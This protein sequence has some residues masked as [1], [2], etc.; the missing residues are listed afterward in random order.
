[1]KSKTDET[2][3]AV[4]TTTLALCVFWIVISFSCVRIQERPDSPL[5]NSTPAAVSQE[6]VPLVSFADSGQDLGKG[7]GNCV[8]LGDVDGDGDIDALYSTGD[9]PSSLRLNDGKGIFTLSEQGFLKSSHAAFGDLNGDSYSDIFFTE[10]TSNQVWL[11]DGKGKF[12]NTDQSLVSPE[13]SSVS[14]GDIDGDGDLD[15]FVTNWGNK[16]DQV[17]VNNGKGKFT[18][19][20]QRLG[21]FSG[22]SIALGDVDKDGD[23]DA[24]VSNNGENSDNSTVLWLNDGKGIFTDSAQRLGLTNAYGVALGDLDGDGDLDAFIANS[25][26]GGANPADTV[27]MNDGRGIFTDSGQSLGKAYSMCVALGDFDGDGD[28]DAFTG[29]WRSPPRIWL[30]DGKGAFKDSGLKMISPNIS[31]AAAA[32]LNGDGNL[33]IFVAANTWAVGGDGRSRLWLN[34]AQSK[35]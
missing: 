21:S 22:T 14:L 32:D 12:T 27:W 4:R 15:A 16:P 33:D 9:I 11:N 7:A 30:N 20:G 29:S 28:F 17:F 1:M 24:M 19:S 8:A 2:G 31:K 23:L 34:Q 3:A 25:S 35:K 6:P 26:H 18:D 5:Q 13:S 10:E